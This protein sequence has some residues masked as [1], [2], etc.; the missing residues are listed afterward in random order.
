MVRFMSLG[1][2]PLAEHWPH[3]HML[4][5][6]TRRLRRLRWPNSLPPRPCQSHRLRQHARP[7]PIRHHLDRLIRLRTQNRLRPL[8]LNVVSEAS[9][10][11]AIST[12]IHERGKLDIIIHNAGHMGYGPAEAFSPQQY[13]DYYDVNCVG[14]QRVNM[15]ALP[16]LR[17]QG[18]GLLLW[19][20]STS[21]RG[22]TPP[23]LAP[24]FAAK[25]AMDSLAV[26]YSTEVSRWGD[27]DEHHG[28]RGV[29]GW[30][31]S[32]R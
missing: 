22:G 30:D 9:C 12:I 24:Y 8:T 20:G 16:H 7:R 4:T 18:R 32:C 6:N 25:A 31:E 10:K 29:Y 26:S 1:Y 2:L 11:T 3:P 28:A 19:V 17:K 5:R 13:L 15:A 27:R 14:P 23:F 21:T